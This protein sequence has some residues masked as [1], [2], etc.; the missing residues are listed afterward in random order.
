MG[1]DGPLA[2]SG[3]RI[4]SRRAEVFWH[5]RETERATRQGVNMEEEGLGRERKR[6]RANAAFNH[7]CE[8]SD[9][10]RRGSGPPPASGLLG[11][12]SYSFYQVGLKPI[13]LLWYGCRLSKFLSY[14]LS[15]SSA[16]ERGKRRPR[17]TTFGKVSPPFSLFPSPQSLLSLGSW[18]TSFEKF[19]LTN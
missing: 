5:S 15:P 8:K 19:M 9:D 10:G 2:R 14:H 16:L 13:G 17:N 4:S 6:R 3:L 12:T 18:V 7:N 1:I 11:M